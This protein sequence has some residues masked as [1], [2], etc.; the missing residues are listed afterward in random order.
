MSATELRSSGHDLIALGEPLVVMIPD[1]TGPLRAVPRFERGMGGA[2]C[3]TLLGFARLG[4]SCGLVSRLGE[5]E[6]GVF[7]A[8]MLQA[9]SIDLQRV[10]IDP[11]R[12]TGLYFKEVLPLEEGGRPIYYRENTAASA[13]RLTEEDLAYIEQGRAFLATGVIAL[14][15][16]QTHAAAKLALRTAREAGV[17]TYFDPNVRPGLWGSER[18]E[19]L[20]GPLIAD[21][22]VF[23]GGEEETRRLTGA[24]DPVELAESIRDLGPR[25][26]V[27]KRGP[28]GAIAL[29]E[30]GTVH[31]QDAIPVPVVEVVGAGDAFNAG[32]LRYRQLGAEVAEA[33]RVGAL[34]GAAVVTGMGD[35][36]TFP[37]ESDLAK[38]L[39]VDE[40]L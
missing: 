35:F 32:Y 36:E 4:G 25:E 22:D 38:Y 28:R 5:D 24:L 12:R 27:I 9:N 23:L 29:D 31:H 17:T 1:R 26:V 13:L 39:T 14:A 15:S 18:A 37:R 3:N 8:G 34:C 33:L 19:E 6:F 2:E 40:T 30:D 7:L 20:I 16:E 10:G 11:D 21:A